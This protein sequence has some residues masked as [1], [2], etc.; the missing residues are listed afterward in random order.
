M[1]PQQTPIQAQREQ[2]EMPWGKHHTEKHAR[3]A[4]KF[5]GIKVVTS[6]SGTVERKI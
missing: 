5:D 3:E 6:A 4:V 2:D 1:N